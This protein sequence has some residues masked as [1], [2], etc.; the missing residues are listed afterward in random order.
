MQFP[1]PFPYPVADGASGHVGDPDDSGGSGIT[2]DL[3]NDAV[4]VGSDG[5]GG[6]GG[7]GAGVDGSNDYYEYYYVYYDEAGNVI[8]CVC[9]ESKAR[10]A[11]VFLN[12]K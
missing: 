10:S 12:T 7:G 5:V 2:D 6:G 11:A 4:V 8:R 9:S 1:G 3:D